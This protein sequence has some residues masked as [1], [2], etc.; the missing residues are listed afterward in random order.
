MMVLGDLRS[1]SITLDSSHSHVSEGRRVLLGDVLT[2][3]FWV[4]FFFFS[5]FGIVFG[6]NVAAVCKALVLLDWFSHA[7]G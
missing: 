3:F 1:S 7:G 4:F 5:F 6:Q 2:F